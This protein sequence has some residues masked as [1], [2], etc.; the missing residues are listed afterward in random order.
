MDLYRIISELVQE[1]NRLQQIIQSLEGMTP[2]GKD[3]VRP[4]GK[5]RGRKSMDGSARAEVSARMK[6]Y[7]A[8]RRKEK[9]EKKGKIASGTPLNA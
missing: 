9:S 7:W 8:K 3:P 2:S 5:R 1:R 4:A 6:L